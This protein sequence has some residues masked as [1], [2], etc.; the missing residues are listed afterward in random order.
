[1]GGKREVDAGLAA[2]ASE[3]HTRSLQASSR[4][5]GKCITGRE[6]AKV[7]EA[8]PR[9]MLPTVGECAQQASSRPAAA[10]LAAAAGRHRNPCSARRCVLVDRMSESS[11]SSREQAEAGTLRSCERGGKPGDPLTRLS[12]AVLTFMAY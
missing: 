3:R 11:G 10:L 12:A 1:V 5:R 4:M 6:G 2:L 8:V 9:R 7:G